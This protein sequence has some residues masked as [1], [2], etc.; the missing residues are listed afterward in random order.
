ME[1]TLY[2]RGSCHLCEEAKAALKPL[3][4]EF[5][6]ALHEVDVD[7]QPELAAQFGEEVPVVFF[8]GRKVAKHRVDVKQ[9]RRRL[10]EQIHHRDTETTEKAQRPR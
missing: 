10:Q 4:R 5:N 1:L 7:S 2:T 9:L 3:L 6:L 8:A